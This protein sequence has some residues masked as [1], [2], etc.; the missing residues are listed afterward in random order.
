M[1]NIYMIQEL[2]NVLFQLLNKKIKIM[3]NEYD[4]K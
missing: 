4:D 3:Y 1:V 2:V